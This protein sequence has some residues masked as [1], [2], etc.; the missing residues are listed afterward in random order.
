[1]GGLTTV[2]LDMLHFKLLIT[3][4]I[5]EKKS[6]LSSV[7]FTNTLTDAVFYV[8]V[9]HLSVQKLALDN[10]FCNSLATE[11]GAEHIL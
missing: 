2:P 6:L 8:T 10:L 11:Y 9:T 7:Y 5:K 1:M 3:F 4:W